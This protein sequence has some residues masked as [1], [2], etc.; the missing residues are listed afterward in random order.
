[1]DTLLETTDTAGLVG[2][3]VTPYDSYDCNTVLLTLNSQV[4]SEKDIVKKVRDYGKKETNFI[5]STD[6]DVPDLLR[7]TPALC[8]GVNLEYVV[9]S[10]SLADLSLM[11]FS[12]GVTSHDLRSKHVVEKLC[13]FMF[14]DTKNS[15][16]ERSI[17]VNL[18]CASRGFGSKLLKY[19]EDIS[20]KLNYNR[21]TLRSLEGPLGFY[22]KKGYQ[23]KK[24]RDSPVYVTS[25]DVENLKPQASQI[26]SFEE[27]TDLTLQPLRGM[28]YSEKRS[29]GSHFWIYTQARG[30]SPY[31]RKNWLYIKPGNLLLFK[32]QVSV[33]GKTVFYNFDSKLYESVKD[34]L[35]PSEISS[36]CFNAN[37][38]NGTHHRVKINKNGGLITILRNI[39]FNDGIFMFKNIDKSVTV[40]PSTTG[41]VISTSAMRQKVK[42]GSKRSR[43]IKKSKGK[44]LRMVALKKSLIAGN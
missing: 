14:L 39:D 11:L 15:K 42:L 27:K 44:N 38:E 28:L 23:L 17:Y 29:N 33:D 41:T 43:K 36:N 22:L 31:S 32:R 8:L 2:T 40:A 30:D 18:I 4:E 19:A 35:D 7:Q 6:I 20:V 13:G 37:D 3:V 1:M 25:E 12:R 21:V 16:K 9:Q 5:E 26:A 34:F 10:F 24:K